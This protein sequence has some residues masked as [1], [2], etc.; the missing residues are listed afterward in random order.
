M[1]LV[2]DEDLAAI[3]HRHDVEAGDNHFA[4]V[5]DL[6]V[7]GRVNLEDVDVASFGNFDARV[8]DAAW[9][10]GRTFHAVERTRQD[11]RRGRFADAARTCE[12]ERLRKTATDEGVL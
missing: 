5:V 11:S 6:G 2:D 1:D 8:T 12:H 3:A 7:R 4:D 10:G 9:L